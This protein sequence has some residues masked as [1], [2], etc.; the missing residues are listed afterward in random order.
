MEQKDAEEES[1]E[2]A[3]KQTET[4]PA[5]ER[6][7]EVKEEPEEKLTDDE[8][9]VCRNLFP[10]IKLEEAKKKYAKQKHAM[11]R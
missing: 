8:I 1:R 3:R 9:R 10:D 4:E 11:G 5:A 2:K 7:R 6:G